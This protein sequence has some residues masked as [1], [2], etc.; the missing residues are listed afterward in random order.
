[1]RVLVTGCAGFIGSHVAEA[2]LAEG[3]D[4]S[5]IDGFT[6]YYP[7]PLKEANLAGLLATAGF[8][9]RE[10]DLRTHPLDDVLDGI[11]AV[12]HLAAM[13]GLPRSWIDLDGYIGCN[14]LATGRL[15]DAAHRAGVRRFVQVSTSS[16]YGLEAVGDEQMP[17]RPI[18]PY[19][20]T[21]LAAEHLV[22]A[23]VDTHGFP[24]TILRY[25][26]I[27]GPRQRPDMAYR[28][29]IDA[30]LAGRP[31]TVYGDGSQ[32][33]SSTYV[34]DCVRATLAA[35]H[36]GRVG[37]VY[38][39][40]GGETVTL[41]DVI[42]LIADETGVEPVLR[43]EAARPGDQ[44]HTAADTSKARAQLGYEP[45]VSA[46]DGIRAQV[47]WQLDLLARGSPGIL[48]TR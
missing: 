17:T 3:H 27:Y 2:L 37:E 1:M 48:A 9:F 22:L 47:A 35:L 44:R 34:A 40:G 8:A 24:A 15:V 7:R 12:I 39:I 38:N 13:P 11:E 33:R 42:E 10:V 45:R 18:S 31:I 19:G 36:V 16:V 28:I 32:S 20:V 4:V 14:L 25:F 23:H 26:S 21:K 41:S 30:M 6:D 29:F 46:V 43:R 5:G